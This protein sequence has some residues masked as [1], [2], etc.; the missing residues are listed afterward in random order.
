MFS[1]RKQATSY[2]SKIAQE[3]D[4]MPDVRPYR[5]Q[6]WEEDLLRKYY[7]RKGIDALARVLKKTRSAI[8]TKASKL[9]TQEELCDK[10][11]RQL[12][13]S[14]PIAKVGCSRS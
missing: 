10:D 1:S 4:A 5:W 13:K 6:P 3:L 11:F 8:I 14:K 2:Q 12:Q 9:F 7:H